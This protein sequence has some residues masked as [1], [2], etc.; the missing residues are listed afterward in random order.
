MLAH[1]SRMKSLAERLER[2]L[3]VYNDQTEAFERIKKID[4]DAP[5][6]P[7]GHP[8]RV[9]LGDAEYFYFPTPYP[10]VRAKADWESVTDVASYEAYTCLAEGARYDKSAPRLDRDG[11]GRVNFSWK[12]NTPPLTPK[13][14][15][16]LIESGQLKREDCPMRLQDAD[17]GKPILLHGG[18]VYWNEYR[19]KWI[20]IGLEAGGTSSPLGEIWFAEATAPQGPWV[21]AKKIVTHN[22]MDFYNPTQHPF[23]DQDGGRFI[24]FEGTYTNSFS[25]N[26]C[27]T[28]RYEYNQIMYRLDLADERLKMP[29]P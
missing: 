5:L 18:S 14:L 7:D 6:A 28:P 27:Q 16:E 4:L 10:N 15:A 11:Q 19:K 8:F 24:Y 2:G 22:K 1:Y 20:M 26:P 29:Q 12:R 3:I 9:M 25:G 17:C 21:H 23:F 13:E